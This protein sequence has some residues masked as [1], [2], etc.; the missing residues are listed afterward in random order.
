MARLFRRIREHRCEYCSRGVMLDD[1]TV[2][3]AKKGVRARADRCHSFRY[4]PCKRIPL[5]PKLPDFEKYDDRDYS[6]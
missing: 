4:D 2:L 6:L 5:K 1:D 3:C